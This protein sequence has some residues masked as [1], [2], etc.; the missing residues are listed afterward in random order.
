[1][2]TD[3]TNTNLNNNDGSGQPSGNSAPAWVAQLPDDLKN[4]ETVTSYKTLGD[5]G[6]AHIETV[7]KVKEFEGKIAN[8][9]IPKL[10]DNATDA[11]RTA[12]YAALGRPESP[13]KYDF[14]GDTKELPLDAWYRQTAYELGLSQS[15]AKVLFEKY[16]GIVQQQVNAAEQKRQESLTAGMETIKKEWGAKYEQNAA[17]VKAV[18]QIVANDDEAKNWITAHNAENDPFLTRLF[19]KIAPALLDDK[20]IQSAA[21]PQKTTKLGM[22]YTTMGEFLG[23]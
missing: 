19:L 5:L 22:N 8:D 4:N 17:I 9:Y 20:A 3:G 13:D 10:K 16:Q 15:Q 23:G 11:E 2:D 14:G 7:G 21:T 18:N 6:K 1:M 12:F